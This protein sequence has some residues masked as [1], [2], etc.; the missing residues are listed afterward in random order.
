MPARLFSGCPIP[1]GPAI[2]LHAWASQAFG[3]M[4]VRLVPVENYHVTLMFYGLLGPKCQQ[5]LERLTE[6][7]AWESVEVMVHR[8]GLYGRSAIGVGL[9]AAPGAGWELER[10]LDPVASLRHRAKLEN[11]RRLDLHVTV[12]RAKERISIPADLKPPS[13]TFDLARLVLYESILS[14]GPAR[15]RPLAQS[16]RLGTDKLGP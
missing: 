8:V 3:A 1:E 7:F 4:N 9:N 11:R 6:E 2:E 5:A 12:A 15:Y 13:L 10:R 16:R 14:S